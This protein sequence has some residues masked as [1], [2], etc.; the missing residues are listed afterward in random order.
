V[1]EHF[2]PIDHSRLHDNSVHGWNLVRH[3]AFAALMVVKNSTKPASTACGTWRGSL[4]S[5]G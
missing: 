4:G 1:T 3:R 2:R 5:E